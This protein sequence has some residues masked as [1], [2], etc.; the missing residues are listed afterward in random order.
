MSDR[1]L[2]VF[3]IQKDLA[4]LNDMTKKCTFYQNWWNLWK[5]IW[6]VFNIEFGSYFITHWLYC[7]RSCSFF[8]RPM[9]EWDRDCCLQKTGSFV[10]QATRNRTIQA[11][12]ARWD[13]QRCHIWLPHWTRYNHWPRVD[14]SQLLESNFQFYFLNYFFAKF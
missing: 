5:L 1:I 4:M 13:V 3:K 2:H 6:K 10:P 8:V 14:H 11:H 7:C 12:A 9:R